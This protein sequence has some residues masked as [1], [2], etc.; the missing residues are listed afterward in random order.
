[1]V[2]A[3]KVTVLSGVSELFEQAALEAIYRAEEIL[4]PKGA[5]ESLSF[6]IKAAPDQQDFAM[7]NLPPSTVLLGAYDPSTA[8][9]ILYESSIRRAARQGESLWRQTWETTVHEIA[10]HLGLN[11]S[12]SKANALVKRRELAICEGCL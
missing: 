3:S 8:T 1:M 4:A 2:Q 9:I 12:G 5:F 6:V 11:H 10:H 7:T